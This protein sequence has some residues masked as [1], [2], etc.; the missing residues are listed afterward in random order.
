VLLR[1]SYGGTFDISRQQ[2]WTVKTREGHYGQFKRRAVSVASKDGGPP[3]N[4]KFLIISGSQSQKSPL[5]LPIPL[6]LIVFFPLKIV[7]N[8]L[9]YIKLISFI[10]LTR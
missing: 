7:F 5:P 1:V 4:P 10:V 2:R 3:S 8:I 6:S 9:F